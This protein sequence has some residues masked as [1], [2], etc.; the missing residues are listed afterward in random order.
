MEIKKQKEQLE[1]QNKKLEMKINEFAE[2]IKQTNDFSEK[3]KY[4]LELGDFRHKNYE[5]TGNE[6]QRSLAK[7]CFY[8]ARLFHYKS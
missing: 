7:N 2:K 1:Q 5:E 6:Y 4:M 8:A 3:E